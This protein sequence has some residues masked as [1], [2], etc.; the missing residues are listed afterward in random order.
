MPK[1]ILAEVGKIA[2]IDLG[3]AGVTCRAGQEAN[4]FGAFGF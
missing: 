4:F 2:M 3:S 1:P